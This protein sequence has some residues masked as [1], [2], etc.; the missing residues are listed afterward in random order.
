MKT[1][2]SFIL[3]S[4]L[5]CM[6]LLCAA[7]SALACGPWLYS[8]ADNGIY[9]IVPPRWQA[10]TTVDKDFP[11]RN[12]VLWSQQ[13][14][15][16]DTAAIRQAVYHGT[17]ADWESLYNHTAS[18]WSS[19]VGLGRSRPARWRV[20]KQNLSSWPCTLPLFT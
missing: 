9:R 2:K 17:L 10:P 3:V 4:L 11:T 8:A 6:A 15:C 13:T 18:R 19:A 7:P 12:V 16:R 5:H 14:G 1:S 20:L